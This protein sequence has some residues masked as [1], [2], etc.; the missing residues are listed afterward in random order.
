M[1]LGD[2]YL[3]LL[4]SMSQ[5]LLILRG[6]VIGTSTEKASATVAATASAKQHAA[7]QALFDQCRVRPGHARFTVGREV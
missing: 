6:Q 2:F 5:A 3:I 7:V 1:T 4:V